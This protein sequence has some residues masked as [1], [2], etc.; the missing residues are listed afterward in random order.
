MRVRAIPAVEMENIV[1]AAG[2]HKTDLYTAAFMCTA[3]GN[4]IIF[5]TLVRYKPKLRER[6]NRSSF[7]GEMEIPS[8]IPEDVQTFTFVGVA[9]T[10]DVRG[11]FK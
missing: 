3:R 8:Y 11:N 10:G 7:S 6:L 2:G 5:D 4:V 1:K 9:K